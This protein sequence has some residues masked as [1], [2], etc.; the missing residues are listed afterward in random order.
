VELKP[1]LIARVSNALVWPVLAVV[2][3]IALIGNE[4]PVAVV[5]VVGI[6]CLAAAVYLGLQGWRVGVVCEETA[7]EIHG[8]FRNRRIPRE[9]I[10]AITTFPAVRWKTAGQARWTP[11]FAFANPVRLV[12]F[13]ERHNEAATAILQD[14]QTDAEPEPPQ[15]KRRR[16]RP[17]R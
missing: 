8:L 10:V 13:V 3:V 6:G 4:A 9:E 1:L 16:Q 7:I 12:P 11:I 15:K 14:W 5:V 2:A 17:A